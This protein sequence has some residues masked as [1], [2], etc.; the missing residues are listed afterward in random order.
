VAAVE[1]LARSRRGAAAQAEEVLE[2]LPDILE[3]LLEV[4]STDIDLIRILL[5]RRSHRLDSRLNSRFVQMEAGRSEMRRC[6]RYLLCRCPMG[7]W[8]DRWCWSDRPPIT[9]ALAADCRTDRRRYSGP[10]SVNSFSTPWYR[11]G[12]LFAVPLSVALPDGS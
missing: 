6:G 3:E 8:Q 9:S 2:E 4:I 1:Q 7:Q 11:N 12:Q 5:S 10:G